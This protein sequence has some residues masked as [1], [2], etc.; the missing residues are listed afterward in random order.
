MNNFIIG[1]AYSE[2]AIYGHSSLNN[3]IDGCYK[4]RP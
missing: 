4:N 2:V 1:Q 3:H